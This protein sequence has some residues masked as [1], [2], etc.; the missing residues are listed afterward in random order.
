MSTE[1]IPIHHVEALLAE[2]PSGSPLRQTVIDALSVGC[3]ADAFDD[4]IDH[5]IACLRKVQLRF[6]R[7]KGQQ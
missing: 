1:T 6:R 5:E 7:M 2:L 4:A 3:D